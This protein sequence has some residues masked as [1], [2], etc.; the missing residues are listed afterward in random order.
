M[1]HD[2]WAARPDDAAT[3]MRIDQRLSCPHCGHPKV[4]QRAA[5]LYLCF[6]CRGNWATDSIVS[7]SPAQRARLVAYR[8]AI[9]AGLYTDWPTR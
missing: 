1:T 6:Q 2:A 7:F 4:V 3:L 8:E 9:R 5:G